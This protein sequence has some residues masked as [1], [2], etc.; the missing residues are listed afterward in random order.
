MEEVETWAMDMRGQARM[1]ESSPV[2]AI[3]VAVAQCTASNSEAWDRGLRR[4]TILACRSRAGSACL[5]FLFLRFFQ[6]MW[7]QSQRRP[8]SRNRCRMALNRVT[9]R[10]PH[11]R[12][13]VV[14]LQPPW[15]SRPYS[16]SQ[17]PLANTQIISL[18]SKMRKYHNSIGPNLTIVGR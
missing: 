15:P 13:P 1:R 14:C 10:P 8:V 4:T 18:N 3:R 16:P 12:P 9:C 2:A 17:C 5:N 11:V 6:V 7:P